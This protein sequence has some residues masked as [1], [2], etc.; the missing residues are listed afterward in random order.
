MALPSTA[1]T[2]HHRRSS[3]ERCL[4]C[5]A[6]ASRLL[7][8]ALIV[9]WRSL[10]SPYDTSASINPPCLYSTDSAN[11]DVLPVLL[12]NVGSAIER[13]I[14]WDGVYFVRIAECGYEYEQTYAFLPLLPLCISFLSRTVFAPLVPII[15][16]RAVLGFSGYVINNVAFVC[17]ALCLYL[18]SVIVL[19]DRELAFRASILFCFNPASIF[20]SSIYSE[21]LYALLTFGGLY[22]FINCYDYWAVLWFAVSGCAR[23]NGVLNAGYICY[24]TMLQV[25]ETLFSRT[26]SYI[27][28]ARTLLGGAIRSLCIFAPFVSFQSYGYLNICTSSSLDKMRPWCKGSW[29]LEIFS[30]QTVAQFSSCITNIVSSTLFNRLLC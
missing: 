8:V 28:T 12:P 4:L 16:Y 22:Y 11:P 20:Y 26:H 3:D 2:P 1:V 29:L 24:R 6:V 10:L 14:V 27:L 17:A 25:N 23:S 19:K 18:L 7:L 13:S 15:G 21:S 9:V 30:S 5:W